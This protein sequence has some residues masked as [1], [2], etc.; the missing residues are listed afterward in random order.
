[1]SQN[2]PEAQFSVEPLPLK[3]ALAQFATGVAIVTACDAQGQYVGLT[4]NSFNAVSLTP[5]LV[6]WSVDKHSRTL[7][8]FEH[9]SHFAVHILAH[10]QHDLAMRFASRTEDRFANLALDVGLGG[11]PLISG[12]LATMQCRTHQRVAAGD[13]I[14]MIGWVEALSE[15]NSEHVALGYHRSQFVPIG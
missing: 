15:T 7:Q 5:P 6:L 3:H 4:V 1:M 13:H 14:I 10:N 8:A 11:V 2:T 12:S 9:A